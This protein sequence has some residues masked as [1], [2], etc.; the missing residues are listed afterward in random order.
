MRQ[1]KKKEEKIRKNTQF[2]YE[3]C[4]P[5]MAREKERERE[6]VNVVF[7]WGRRLKLILMEA[8]CIWAN[9]LAR[10]NTS[11]C[12]WTNFFLRQPTSARFIISASIFEHFPTPLC[13]HKRFIRAT[14]RTYKT[15]FSQQGERERGSAR[16]RAK[17]NER[18]NSLA[19][20]PWRLP[21]ATL[22]R[23]RVILIDPNRLILNKVFFP[24]GKSSPPS[25]I[26]TVAGLN[27]AVL[28]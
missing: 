5:S 22:S 15:E 6:S 20:L 12:Y 7:K 2:K 11:V 19:V 21:P 1:K 25:G 9:I 13:R 23:D 28:S 4:L 18:M 24:R 3:Y 16:E 17:K 26:K 10:L 14:S 27:N 8:V